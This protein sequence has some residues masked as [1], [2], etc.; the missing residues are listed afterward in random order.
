VVLP[1]NRRLL[2]ESH[3]A[4]NSGSGLDVLACCLTW[5]LTSR[6]DYVA[7][8]CIDDLLQI[9]LGRNIF[10]VDSLVQTGVCPAQCVN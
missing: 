3:S 4:A 10:L 2:M 9:P 1:A 5:R 8:E 7:V 6:D